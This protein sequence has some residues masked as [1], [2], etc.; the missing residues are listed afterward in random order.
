VAIQ[1]ILVGVDGSRGASAALACAA[2]LGRELGAEL[3][4][5]HAF[6]PLALLGKVDPPVDFARLR[7]EREETLQVEWCRPLAERGLAFRARMVEGEPV[8]A[9]VDAAAGEEAGL[10]VVGTRGLGGFRGLLLGS[11][12]SKLLQRARIPVVVVPE[13]DAPA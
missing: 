13:P 11:V 3:V 7:R 1:R 2:E 10:L 8:T 4:V 9:L 5:V 12:T 6:E